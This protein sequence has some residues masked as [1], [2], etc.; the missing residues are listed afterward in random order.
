MAGIIWCDPISGIVRLS[1]RCCSL[2]GF[3]TWGPA[4]S[5][6]SI[7]ERPPELSHAPPIASL[8]PLS[9]GVQ[10]WSELT[11]AAR[12]VAH[13][14]AFRD[15]TAASQCSDTEFRDIY[16]YIYPLDS[17]ERIP[18]ESGHIVREVS[19]QRG[20]EG[21]TGAWQEG[22]SSKSNRHRTQKWRSTTQPATASTKRPPMPGGRCTGTA[23]PAPRVEEGAK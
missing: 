21:D 16:I 23:D 3:E 14:C 5:Y 20:A 19:R 17:Q 22:R 4:P 10:S 2:I 1:N 7:C 13:E 18:K 12:Y 11:V 15:V 6:L 9:T 8:P